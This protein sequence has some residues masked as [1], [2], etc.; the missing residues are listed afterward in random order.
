MTCFPR[1]GKPATE[2]CVKV[3][4]FEFDRELCGRIADDASGVRRKFD[5]GGVMRPERK[6]WLAGAGALREGVC[7]RDVLVDAPESKIVVVA[8][9]FRQFPNAAASCTAFGDAKLDKLESVG[10]VC[11][12]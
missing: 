10:K 3:L 1:L 8:R 6:P 12:P 9:P 11:P 7:V 5:V 4:E 2:L